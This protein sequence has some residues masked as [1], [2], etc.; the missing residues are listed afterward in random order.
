MTPLTAARPISGAFPCQARRVTAAVQLRSARKDAEDAALDDMRL[1]ESTLDEQEKKRLE[2]LR[3]IQASLDEVEMYEKQFRQQAAQQRTRRGLS[4]EE[5]DEREIEVLDTAWSGQAGMDV[6]VVGSK[7][8]A[9]ISKR[10][11]LAA[12]DVI[13]LTV[14]ASIGRGVHTGSGID[15]E[16]FKTALPFYIGWLGLSPLLGA[17]TNQAT[18]TQKDMI[19]TLVPAWAVSIP[20]ALAIRG[21]VKG[22]V[23]PV[24][25]IIVSLIATGSLLAAW[26]GLYVVINPTSTAETKRGGILDGFRMITTLLRRW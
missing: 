21:A 18:A 26:R 11:G 19:S 5:E 15:F 2:G 17:Y 3:S 9:D 1:D 6:T 20:V 22:D 7:T 25:F 4:E 10:L 12:G 23:P 24:P 14:F 13:A 8:W 16:V